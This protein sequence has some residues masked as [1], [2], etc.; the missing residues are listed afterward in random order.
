LGIYNN[1]PK[2]ILHV[3]HIFLSVL[4]HIK[5]EAYPLDLSIHLMDD[6]EKIKTML[7]SDKKYVWHGIGKLCFLFP[8]TDGT[9]EY[10]PAIYM[11]LNYPNGHLS[12]GLI[13]YL[14]W[15]KIM[16]IQQLEAR[17]IYISEHRSPDPMLLSDWKKLRKET[18]T[19]T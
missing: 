4:P 12:T 11:Y 15:L 1:G 13:L 10:M 14:K 9:G 16:G 5:G 2:P 3:R 6:Y 17:C 18:G 8:L 7:L 19:S